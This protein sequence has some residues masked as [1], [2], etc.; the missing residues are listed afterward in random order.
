MKYTNRQ[1]TTIA[2]EASD[3][4]RYKRAALRAKVDFNAWVVAQCERTCKRDARR[5][6]R[7]MSVNAPKDALGL[8]P[9]DYKGIA[10]KFNELQA[11]APKRD[12]R[13]ISNRKREV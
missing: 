4:E 10:E 3:L 8:R 2:F 1:V 9:K 13:I 11:R 6:D 5:V 12:N 7:L